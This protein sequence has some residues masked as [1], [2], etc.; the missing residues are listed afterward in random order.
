MFGEVGF[1]ATLPVAK[2]HG[3]GPKTTVKMRALRS[4]TG[5]D[6]RRQTLDFLQ[7]RFGNSGSWYYNIAR[8]RDDRL[9]QPDRERKSSGSETFS[10]DLI[11]PAQIEA[12]VIQW[13]TMSGSGARKRTFVGGPS[14]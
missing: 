12:G 9:V 1:V 11:D 2:F 7:D 10:E 4:E 8:G 3:V 13:L 6:L 14:R 5:A